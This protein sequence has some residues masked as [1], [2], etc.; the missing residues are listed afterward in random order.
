MRSWFIE[1]SYNQQHHI[2]L[3][4][5]TLRYWDSKYVATDI[6]DLIKHLIQLMLQNTA[7]QRLRIIAQ[8]GS[9]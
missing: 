5:I 8:Q 7:Q 2:D 4:I 6:H 9:K 3:Q 1:F